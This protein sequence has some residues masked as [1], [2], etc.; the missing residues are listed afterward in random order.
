MSQ[1]GYRVPQVCKIIDIS[2]RQLD[3]W[4]RTNLIRPSIADARGSGSQRLYSYKDL[5]ELKLIKSLLDGGVSLQRVRKVIDYVREHLGEDVAS[6]N[7]VVDG[8]GS[9]LAQTG[10]EVV[11][12]LRRGQGVL[13]ILP[14]AG[15]VKELDAA[16]CELRP[17][18]EEPEMPEE[19]SPRPIAG[20]G[21]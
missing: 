1:E 18:R 16:I 20:H 17:K 21:S 3:Y 4:A 6:A 13:N 5:V 7:L 14:L 11:D 19:A 12:L 9:V 10:E 8:A 2:Y 15:M